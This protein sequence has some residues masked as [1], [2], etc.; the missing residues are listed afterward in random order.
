MLLHRQFL[1]HARF[2]ARRQ[3]VLASRQRHFEVDESQFAVD[4]GDEIFTLDDR[5][6]IQHV[7][8]EHFPGTDLLFDHVETRLFDIHGG[9]GGSV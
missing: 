8:V 1:Q 6:Q 9:F 7:L 5:E 4:R 3:H 2:D